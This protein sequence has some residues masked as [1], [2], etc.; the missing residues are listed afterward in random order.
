MLDWYA[1]FGILAGI[2]PLVAAIPYI[3][4]ILARKSKPNVVSWSIWTVVVLIVVVG[5]FAEGLSW[6]VAVVIGSTIQNFII[7]F[8]CA[9]GYG[10]K[11]FR[12]VDQVCLALAIL[13]IILWVATADALVAIL[14]AILADAIA[15]IP[16]YAKILR[17][18]KSETY[19]FWGTLIS[20]D[21]L[22]VLSVSRP[23]LANLSFPVAYIVLNAGIFVFAF[24]SRVRRKEVV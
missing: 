5:Q 15:Y 20:A 14:L 3:R 12:R 13:A 18:P 1:V 11:E 16:T 19:S 10:Y 24:F 6:S 21:F 9:L 22:A 7:L 8:L 17:D 23:T 2:L 4:D